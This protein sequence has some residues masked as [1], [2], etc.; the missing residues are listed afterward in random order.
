MLVVEDQPLYRSGLLALVRQSRRLRLVGWAANGAE[1]IGKIR[2][3]EPD[4]ALIDLEMPILDG[5]TV[6][7][8]I[9]RQ[10]LETKP[11][12]L[13]GH[14]RGD[15]VYEA[16][17]EGAAAY[18]SK[19]AGADEIAYAIERVAEGHQIISPNLEGELLATI[20]AHGEE[21]AGETLSAR[22]REVLGLSAEGLSAPEIAERL[23]I[24]TSTVRT[25]LQRTHRKL[26]ASTTAAAVAEAIRR[27]I[28]P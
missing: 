27:R 9:R 3:L 15:V 26:G 20:R 17:T 1:A 24:G 21:A 16:L 28:L 22:E 11:I 2:E 19:A 4:V 14:G 7:R 23:V 12:V 8:E 13:S 25:H 18:L 10:G 6:L 5:L